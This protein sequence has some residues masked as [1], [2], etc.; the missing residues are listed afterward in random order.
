MS[1]MKQYVFLS[2][3]IPF[4][5]KSDKKGDSAD[6]KNYFGVGAKGGSLEKWFSS[7]YNQFKAFQDQFYV[8]GYRYWVNESIPTIEIKIHISFA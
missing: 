1:D 3:L 6:Q 5:K 7:N 2:N 8:P 4:L